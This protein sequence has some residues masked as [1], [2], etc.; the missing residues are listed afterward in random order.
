MARLWGRS[1]GKR[2][3]SSLG[4]DDNTCNSEKKDFSFTRRS[5]HSASGFKPRRWH[6][7]IP[8]A[9]SV[10]CQIDLFVRLTTPSESSATAL[11]THWP[12][13]T[14]LLLVSSGNDGQWHH[15][16]VLHGER[17]A[18]SKFSTT[19]GRKDAWGLP[20]ANYHGPLRWLRAQFLQDDSGSAGRFQGLD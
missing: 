1:S 5:L 18:S 20:W 11:M 3:R 7:A 10:P 2:K 9:H 17:R 4:H 19:V 8:A 13:T 16:F 12:G 6:V 14:R 15:R